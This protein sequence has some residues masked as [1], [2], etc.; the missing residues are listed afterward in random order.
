MNLNSFSQTL[1]ST[2]KDT[3]IC[4]SLNRAK[5]LLKEHYNLQECQALLNICESQ[6]TLLDSLI[7]NQKLNANNLKGI[8]LN[9]KTL[10]SYKDD[11]I[12]LL[13]DKI[14][15]EQKEVRKQKVYKWLAIVGGVVG[16]TFV[17]Y[18]YLTK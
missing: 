11:E 14:A 13:N 2:K 4:F 8:I 15:Y 12:S 1:V 5:Y 16:T 10:V 18:K 9:Q 6:K 17:T 7:A 3:S